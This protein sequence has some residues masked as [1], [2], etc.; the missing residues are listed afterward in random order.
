MLVAAAIMLAE[1]DKGKEATARKARYDAY[2]AAVLRWER[3]DRNRKTALRDAY[4]ADRNAQAA[5]R[6]THEAAMMLA[7]WVNDLPQRW[8]FARDWKALTLFAL[9]LG[10]R[11]VGNAAFLW[12][13]WTMPMPDDMSVNDEIWLIGFHS[14]N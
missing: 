11:E 4:E 8:Q 7:P 1:Y 6:Y 9:Q 2:Q 10:D 13:P 12:M 3:W 5:L 14:N